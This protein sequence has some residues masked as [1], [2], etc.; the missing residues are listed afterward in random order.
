[1]DFDRFSINVKKFHGNLLWNVVI[2]EEFFLK[3]GLWN[4]RS[5]AWLADMILLSL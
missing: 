3:C 1:M 5:I 2:E 4:K